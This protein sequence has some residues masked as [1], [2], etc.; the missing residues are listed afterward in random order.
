[1]NLFK[2]ENKTKKF[3]GNVAGT[4]LALGALCIGAY[5][6]NKAREYALEKAEELLDDE[7][8][9]NAIDNDDVLL[10]KDAV[11]ETTPIIQEQFVSVVS[12]GTAIPCDRTGRYFTTFRTCPFERTTFLP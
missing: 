8:N 11:D 5:V 7:K 3:V 9:K 10:A 6:L 12:Q 4:A 2:K 1:M